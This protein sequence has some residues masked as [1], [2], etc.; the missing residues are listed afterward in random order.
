MET[1]VDRWYSERLQKEMT[2]RT[3]GAGGTPVL[4][5]PPQEMLSDAYEAAGVTETLARWL[6]G[7]MIRLVT[8]DTIDSE[9]WFSTD[10]RE[11]RANRQEARLYD[12]SPLDFLPNMAN[13]HPYIEIY[14]ARK[15]VFCTGQGEGLD[16]PRR[17][18]DLLRSVLHERG[19]N[20][21]VD[22]WGT[23]VDYGWEWWKKQ[24]VYFL[25]YVLGR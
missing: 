7:R 18:T 12:N 1:R 13:E 25:P 9:S 4:A 22:F 24:L 17:T 3:Y 10:D 8:V 6:D 5:F 11:W 14:N 15:M 20:A 2:V 23:D 21:W 16:E 19:I